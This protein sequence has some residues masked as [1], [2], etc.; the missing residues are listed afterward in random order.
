MSQ[1]NNI[2]EKIVTQV[3]EHLNNTKSEKFYLKAKN[4]NDFLQNLIDKY[5]DLKKVK[6]R[7][8]FSKEIGIFKNDILI[9]LFE[10]TQVNYLKRQINSRR[11]VWSKEFMETVNSY[12]HQT[13]RITISYPVFSKE[14]DIA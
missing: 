11:R 7:D 13:E 2:T 5:S 4:D 12:E 10:P 9:N 6:K 8:S 1:S 3:F 14:T